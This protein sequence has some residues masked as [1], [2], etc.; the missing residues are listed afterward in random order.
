MYIAKVPYQLHLRTMF[1]SKGVAF[2]GGVCDLVRVLSGC[3]VRHTK[4]IVLT[5]TSE[6]V[7]L[8]QQYDR[9]WCFVITT[10]HDI[11]MCLV[12]QEGS[13]AILW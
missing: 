13:A 9:M 5:Y 10:D 2:L 1:I 12:Q 4:K 6:R 3:S 8:Q 11:G 7:M